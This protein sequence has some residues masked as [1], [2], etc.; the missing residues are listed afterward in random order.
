MIENI[1]YKFAD[2]VEL[3]QIAKDFLEKYI[4]LHEEN[5]IEEELT[6]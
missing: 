6:G 5:G 4:Y 1:Q 3:V 2:N